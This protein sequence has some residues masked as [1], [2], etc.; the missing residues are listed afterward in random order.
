MYATAACKG[1][2][3]AHSMSFARVLLN[4]VLNKSSSLVTYS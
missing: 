2:S 1:N 3:N 4:G